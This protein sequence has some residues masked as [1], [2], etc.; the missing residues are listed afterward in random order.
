MGSPYELPMAYVQRDR[1]RNRK[2]LGGR[3]NHACYRLEWKKNRIGESKKKEEEIALIVF[4]LFLERFVITSY[5]L[6]LYSVVQPH[7]YERYC[8]FHGVET[9]REINQYFALKARP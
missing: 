2:A 6:W 5:I 4:F 1:Q 9:S 7:Q 8:R 3:K